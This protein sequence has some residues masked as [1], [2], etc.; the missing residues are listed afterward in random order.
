MQTIGGKPDSPF[1]KARVLR[2]LYRLLPD[3]IR[4]L[5]DEDVHADAIIPYLEDIDEAS[6]DPDVI[7]SIQGSAGIRAIY[8]SIKSQVF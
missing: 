6:L 1:F 7:R 5:E 8:Q 4:D 2:A 3:I